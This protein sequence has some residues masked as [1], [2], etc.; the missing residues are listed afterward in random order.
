MPDIG[1]LMF[2]YLTVFD[3]YLEVYIGGD[4]NDKL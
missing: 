3:Q 2:V 1:Y 4:T